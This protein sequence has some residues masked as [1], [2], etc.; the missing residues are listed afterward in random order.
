MSD[1]GTFTCEG[2]DGDYFTGPA[3]EDRCYCEDC[4]LERFPDPRFSATGVEE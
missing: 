3:W 1:Y 2:C 4:Y